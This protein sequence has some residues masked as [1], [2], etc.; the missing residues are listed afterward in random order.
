MIEQGLRRISQSLLIVLGLAIFIT[1]PGRPIPA[2]GLK[3]RPELLV[4]AS[5]LAGH[6]T[7]KD[8]RIVDVRDPDAYRQGHIP[9]AVNIPRGSLFITANG[10]PGMMPAVDR[11]AVQFGEAGIGPDTTVVVYDD[12]SG[13]YASRLFWMLD[14]LG[15]GKGRMLDGN[16]PIWKSGGHP[17]S[18][19]TPNIPPATFV[20]RPQADKIADLKWMRGHLED[21]TTVYVDARSMLEFRGVTK[22]AK[23]RGHIP[24]ALSLEWKRHLKG[25]GTLRP[26][27]D[28]TREYRELGV[29][30]ERDIAV[31]CQVMVRASHSYFTLKWL[32]YPKV[33]GYDGSWAEWGNR[34]DTPKEL[35]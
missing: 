7:E 23:Y 2:A 5:W 9:G 4:S 24:G 11:V 6:L 33:R 12:S 34:E 10:V 32:G 35:F 17:V 15:Q 31:Y 25:D 29:V 22:Y 19:E 18:R 30:P 16:W 1:I 26:A 21:E 8:M 13:L 27:E 14:Y 20:P 28:L 3:P